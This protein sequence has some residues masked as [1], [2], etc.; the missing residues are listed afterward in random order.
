MGKKSG[1]VSG[2]ITRARG[3]AANLVKGI[4]IPLTFGFAQTID[5]HRVLTMTTSHASIAPEVFRGWLDAVLKM[6]EH[7]VRQQ[8]WVAS[9][10]AE[11]QSNG[12]ATIYG[13]GVGA[14]NCSQPYQKCMS[15]AC[16]EQSAH[17][18]TCMMRVG[19]Y[20]HQCRPSHMHCHDSAEWVCPAVSLNDNSPVAKKALPLNYNATPFVVLKQEHSGS[21]WFHA[22]LVQLP[23]GVQAIKEFVRKE[24]FNESLQREFTE[25]GRFPLSPDQLSQTLLAGTDCL[26]NPTARPITA[27]GFTMDMVEGTYAQTRSRIHCSL[28][29][30]N[31]RGMPGDG[32]L[33]AEWPWSLAMFRL[34]LVGIYIDTRHLTTCAASACGQS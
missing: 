10:P 19:S 7:Q 2:K 16:C 1:S 11:A 28:A 3:L 32:N 17:A 13:R 20:F 25:A 8:T 6:A 30:M 33:R 34:H 21:T 22:L 9:L 24:G 23:G 14:Q 29:I 31:P 27:C 15:T 18:Y 26:V 4:W 5:T 12:M